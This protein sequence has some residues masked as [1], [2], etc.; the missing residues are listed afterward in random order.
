[1]GTWR[2]QLDA[3]RDWKGYRRALRTLR[4]AGPVFE[5]LPELSYEIAKKN[6]H[7]RGYASP[8]TFSLLLDRQLPDTRPDW[9]KVE[10][11]VRI[12]L[13]HQ[14]YENASVIVAD[15]AAAYRLC[16][17]DPGP[18]F[19][20]LPSD[21]AEVFL[22]E[23]DP[24]STAAAPVSDPVLAAGLD[25]SP[26]S[27][28]V[29]V[30]AAA[31]EEAGNRAEDTVG[32]PATGSPLDGRGET[33]VIETVAGET[34]EGSDAANRRKRL[35]AV[36]AAVA[37]VVT[38]GCG[39]VVLRGFGDAKGEGNSAG[40][41]PHASISA[42]VT[43]G[44]PASASA[45]AS[46]PPA[47]S[48]TDTAASSGP[49]GNPG[50]AAGG[51]AGAGGNPTPAAQPSATPLTPKTSPPSPKPPVVDPATDSKPGRYVSRIAWSDNGGSTVVQVYADY[52]DTDHGRQS[53]TGHGY[54][55]G[56]DI[57]VLCQ[58]AGRAVP[59][60][61]YHG[62]AARNG[63]WYRMSTGEYIPAVYVDTGKDSLPAC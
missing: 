10:L 15:W 62:P 23:P 18:R 43:P 60:G 13:T 63:L 47:A 30:S 8:G 53:A 24:G 2:E 44:S 21:P 22:V 36:A 56:Q 7:L 35:V 55:I 14:G 17:G 57:V 29:P 46:A 59:L 48:G 4:E 38:I 11:V 31:R 32:G 19:P 51:V 20:E 9:L 52:A 16:G 39:V 26:A 50:Q 3:A 12:C 45:S 5:E 25:A 37:V 33:A 34:A 58:V 6:P 40:A 42:P 27:G 49:G 1:M 28:P 41:A 54:D 61:D